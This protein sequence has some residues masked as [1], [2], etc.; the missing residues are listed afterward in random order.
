MKKLFVIILAVILGGM[1]FSMDKKLEARGTTT[2][3][4]G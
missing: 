4:A 1:S 2:M 3:G